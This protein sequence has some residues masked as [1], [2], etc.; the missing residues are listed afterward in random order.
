MIAIADPRPSLTMLFANL[1]DVKYGSQEY[2]AALTI[3]V[4]DDRIPI[5]GLRRVVDAIERREKRKQKGKT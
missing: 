2:D 3:M 1:W 5:A 4:H